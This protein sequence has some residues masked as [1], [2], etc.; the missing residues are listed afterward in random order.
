MCPGKLVALKVSIASTYCKDRLHEYYTL[1]TVSTCDAQNKVY[2]TA[3]DL[4]V[5]QNISSWEKCSYVCSSDIECQGWSW[6]SK[7][8]K[9]HFKSL[10]GS[11]TLQTAKGF[12][13]GKAGCEPG[14]SVPYFVKL[15]LIFADIIAF[16]RAS[17]ATSLTI[18]GAKAFLKGKAGMIYVENLSKLPKFSE[19][20][21]VVV[22]IT[23]GVTTAKNKMDFKD[24]GG[25]NFWIAGCYKLDDG[26]VN[27]SPEASFI[28][29]RPD[30][31]VPDYCLKFYN[32]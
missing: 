21:N 8:L 6:D 11:P 19:K 32:M 17:T 5:A 12:V 7:T 29:G 25:Q 3:K 9:C 16:T 13:S 2:S 27:F 28:N 22:T 18:S 20:S 24:Y 31:E 15:C 14:I 23:D 30:E 10:A 26:V 4:S 1:D